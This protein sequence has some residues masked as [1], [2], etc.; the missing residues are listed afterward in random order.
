[1]FNPGTTSR[2]GFDPILVT[3][4]PPMSRA[5]TSRDESVPQRSRKRPAFLAELSG[6]AVVAIALGGFM[7]VKTPR[8]AE[9][10][11]NSRETAVAAATA[12]CELAAWKDG[13]K[14]DTLAAAHA[15]AGDFEKAVKYQKQAI[16][17]D[18]PNEKEYRER[19]ALYEAKKP[20][21]QE[22]VKK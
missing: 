4:R 5:Q 19:L 18:K 13:G 22:P 21:R 12:A 15:E 11:T 2:T 6:A 20:Y 10:E 17:L 16:E 1:M 7:F 3:S 8:V 14:L 9:G